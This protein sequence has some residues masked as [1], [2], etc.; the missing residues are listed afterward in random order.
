MHNYMAWQSNVPHNNKIQVTVETVQLSVAWSRS[1]DTGIGDR[2]N[3]GRH[4][5]P[6]T[7]VYARD[8]M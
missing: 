6:A 3:T 4:L 1:M 7:K 5:H 8:Q 2:E